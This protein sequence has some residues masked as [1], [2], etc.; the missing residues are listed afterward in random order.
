MSTL[1]TGWA[2]TLQSWRALL[3]RP[4][5][6]I[7]AMLTL[8]LGVATSTTVFSLLDQALLRP[9]PFPEPDRL[10]TLGMQMEEGGQFLPR[11]T[12]APGFYPPVQRMQG[13]ARTGMVLR[14]VRSSNL[15]VEGVAEVVPSLTADSGFLDTL[16]MPLARGRNFNSEENRPGGPQAA[17]ISHALWQRRF[18]GRADA[19][20]STLWVEGA[21]VPVIGVLSAGFD[22]PD[23]FDVLLPM[24]PDPH[25]T[26]IAANEYIIARLKPG[27]SLAAAGAETDALLRPVMAPYAQSE[28][29]RQSI[30]AMRFGALP[31]R[32]SVF[33]SQSGNVLWMFMAAA[34]CVLGIA[35]FNLGNLMLLR[36]LTRDHDLA[37]RAALG[38][39]RWRLALPALAEA[40]LIGLAGAATGLLFSAMMLAILSDW[41]PFEWLRGNAP[42]LGL[43][44]VLFALLAGVAVAALGAVIGIVRGQRG[45]ALTTLGRRAS[46]GLGRKEGR[47]ARGLI[48]GQV[49][50]AA[51]LLL[52]AS[53]FAHSLFKL[54]QVPMGFASESIVTFTLSPVRASVP[55]IDS[56]HRQTRELRQALNREP[57]VRESGVS[58]NLPTASQFNMYAQFPDGRGTSVQ[59]RPVSA[60][61]LDVFGIALI[62]VAAFITWSQIKR[63]QAGTL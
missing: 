39:P 59:F 6:L 22:W 52:G 33:T 50:V 8:A 7:L 25:S 14:A 48:V 9:L 56:V 26:L 54:S 13:A 3:R 24:Q 37:V 23:R 61:Y 19:I 60:G 21:P 16:G 55:D 47:L 29:D 11:N 36:Q 46:G 17:I 53:L 4:G 42:S 27:V 41:V 62:A 18:G 28:S 31:L 2:E 58:T 32:E 57:G 1:T 30:A 10:V 38:A 5:Y 34:L 40:G 20:G 12:G 49:A 45:N 35:A 44:A 51:V 15:A 63:H 43:G